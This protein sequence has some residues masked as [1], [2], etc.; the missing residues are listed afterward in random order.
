VDLFEHAAATHDAT[1][2]Q[3]V[4]EFIGED[5]TRDSLRQ[6][7]NP[8]DVVTRQLL[9]LTRAHGRTPLENPIF[10]IGCLQNVAREESFTGAQFDNGEPVEFGRPLLELFGE[11][12]AEN[13]IQ[14]RR[15]VKVSF[16]TNWIAR[17]RVIKAK[18]L[19]H[20]IPE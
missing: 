11:K 6:F 20:V 13:G 14:V 8:P 1:H 15:C 16:W 3:R 2:W 4:E 12:A 10:E 18:D 17:G 9:L 5:A 19:F 7:V